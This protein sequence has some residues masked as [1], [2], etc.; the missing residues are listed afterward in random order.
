MEFQVFSVQ[1]EDRL[2]RS[3]PSEIGR[4]Q[5]V[6]SIPSAEE[7]GVVLK[8]QDGCVALVFGRTEDGRSV[9]VRVQGVLPKLYYELRIGETQ[10]DVRA[11]VERSLRAVGCS[12]RVAV[13][14]RTFAHMCGYVPAPSST[15]GR[16]AAQE[17]HAARN[18]E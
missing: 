14:R 11:E 18:V 13:V 2:P 8:T 9:C 4:E 7:S 16:R 1:L 17:A 12:E 5:L 15:S 6:D 10:Y 3:L